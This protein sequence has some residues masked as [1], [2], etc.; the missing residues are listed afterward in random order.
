MLN[1]KGEVNSMK[2]SKILV[3]MFAFVMVCASTLTSYAEK[4]STSEFG[5]FEYYINAN[6]NGI[7]A[8]TTIT[9]PSSS[10][11]LRTY[12]EM[13]NN[14]TGQVIDYDEDS[15]YGLSKTYVLLWKPENIKKV[16]AFAT[17]EARGKGSIARFTSATL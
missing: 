14:A 6:G 13:Q 5:V 2:K 10:T 17:H 16:A 1:N 15:G 4:V 12:E 11:L 7:G 9:K 8:S 3:F